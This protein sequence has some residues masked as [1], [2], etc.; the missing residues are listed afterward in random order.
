MPE[1]KGALVKLVDTSLL[2]CLMVEGVT[3]RGWNLLGV[4]IHLPLEMGLKRENTFE[5][6]SSLDFDL[7]VCYS[8]FWAFAF[9][10]R[11]QNNLLK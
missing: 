2:K 3:Q 8:N 11:W 9:N 6:E 1:A 7:T 4:S 10:Q 5:F